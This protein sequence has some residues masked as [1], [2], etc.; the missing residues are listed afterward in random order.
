[1]S[2]HDYTV[3]KPSGCAA[4]EHILSKVA[5]DYNIDNEKYLSITSYLDCVKDYVTFI[6]KEEIVI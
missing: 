1:M 4:T 2:S 6:T 3:G 5:K